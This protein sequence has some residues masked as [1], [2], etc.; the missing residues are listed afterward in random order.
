MN[1]H[2]M[3]GEIFFLDG[4]VY[5]AQPPTP[6]GGVPRNSLAIDCGM[7]FLSETVL[8]AATPD[9]PVQ[10]QVEQLAQLILT[11]ANPVEVASRVQALLRDRLAQ[12]PL[13]S[14]GSP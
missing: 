6:E 3:A 4:L 7:T 8:D 14:A 12:P 13:G 2:G 1:T 10:A 11:S 9:D 5:D